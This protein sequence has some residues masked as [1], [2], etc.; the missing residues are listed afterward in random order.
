MDAWIVWL[1]AAGILLGVEVLTQ[2]MWSL[3]LTVGFVA[4]MIVSLLG[5]GI[6][7]QVVALIAGTFV[8]YLI[9]LPIFRRRH[10]AYVQKSDENSRTGMD[11]LLGRHATVTNEIRPGETGRVRID[12]DN[13]LVKAPGCTTVIQRGEE[14]TVTGYESI[15]LQVVRKEN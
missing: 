13:W 4:A 12:G 1:I 6:E 8:G 11:A 9:L 15:I 14:V 3:C 10:N 5:P 7:W 2:S